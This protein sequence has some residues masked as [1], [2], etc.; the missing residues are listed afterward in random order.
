MQSNLH[1]PDE[2]AAAYL[3][4]IYRVYLDDEILEMRINRKSLKLEALMQK[5]NVEHCVLVTAYNPLGK[6]ISNEEN[7]IRHQRLRDDIYGN[8]KF[9]E[10]DGLDPTA[11]WKPEKS[12][13][14]VGIKLDVAR[15]LS[16]KHEQLAF[17]LTIRIGFARLIATDP[18]EQDKLKTLTF[19]KI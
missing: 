15:E 5:L 18:E 19:P 12:L 17:V 14:I 16:R 13:F 3:K 2:L 1:I 11:I 8:W 7:E 4:S 10:G 6:K 9:L